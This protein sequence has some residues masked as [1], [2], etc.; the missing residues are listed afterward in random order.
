MCIYMYKRR[1]HLVVVLLCFHE[2][3]IDITSLTRRQDC[4]LSWRLRHRIRW[5]SPWWLNRVRKDD[6]YIYE[7]ISVWMY[8]WISGMEWAFPYPIYHRV[9]VF[10]FRQE[11]KKGRNKMMYA[12]AHTTI[13]QYTQ[14]ISYEKLIICIKV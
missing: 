6:Y 1:K 3:K 12:T 4:G 2:I 9:K 14:Y 8:V 10:I 7:Y 11:Q 5:R 13:S